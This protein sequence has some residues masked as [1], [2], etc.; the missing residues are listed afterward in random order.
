[1]INAVIMAGGSG[2]R[3][4]P[5]STK[6]KPKQ[7][8][9]LFGDRSMIQSTVDRLEGVVQPENCMVVTN[10]RYTE[11][12]K[13]QLPDIPDR[14]IIGEPVA[15]NTAP[16][17]AAAAQILYNRNPNAVMLVLPADHHI[18]NVNVFESLLK[19]AVKI[20]SAGESLVTIGIRPNRPETGYGYIHFNAKSRQS[21]NTHDFFEVQNFTEKPDLETARDF[22]ESGEFLWNSG[23]FIWKAETILKAFKKYQGEIYENLKYLRKDELTQD[24][25]DLFYHAC[26]SIS[27]DYGIMEKAEKVLVLPG[28]F[29]WNDVGSW[30]AVHELADRDSSENSLQAIATSVYNASGNLVESESGKMIALVGVHN[31]AVVETEEAILVCN[32]KNSQ[33]VRNIVEQ[34]KEN[35]DLV[36]YL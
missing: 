32:L 11:M 3:F 35:P 9:R 5:L 24:D 4:W 12:V 10:S 17:I 27:V 1:M 13:T 23:M 33:E 16:C 28:D 6:T 36:K 26:P 30:A 20:A 19:E 14:Y 29:G 21:I 8:L 22:L 2:T 15:R 18:T 7:F 31:L 25:I 34:V